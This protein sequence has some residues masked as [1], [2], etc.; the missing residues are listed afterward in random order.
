MSALGQEQTSRRQALMSGLPQE[1]TSVSAIV[2]S[3]LCQKRTFCAAVEALLFDHLV[4]AREQSRG[5]NKPECVGRL[6]VDDELELGRQYDRKVGGL[7]SFENAASVNANHAK[8]ICHA[9]SVAHQAASLGKLSIA[10][11]RGQR[12]ARRRYC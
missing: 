2:M 8:Q 4:G 1:Q 5:D 6:Q 3:A 9:R 11:N 10:M 12:V 7:F